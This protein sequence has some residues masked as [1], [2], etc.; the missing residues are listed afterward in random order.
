MIVLYLLA[1]LIVL[2][3]VVAAF[4]GTGWTFEKNVLI[5]APRAT[6]WDHVNSLGAINTWNPWLDRDPNLHQE[7]TGTDGTP[8]A[9]YSW[10]SKEKNVGAGRQTILSV[11]A[12]NELTTRIQFIRPFKGLAASYIRLEEERGYTR[13]AWG[14]DS[15]TPYPMNII[16]L[17][18]VIEKNMNRDF[19]KGLNKLKAICEK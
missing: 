17:F 1:G 5:R 10:D 2:F 4:V 13:A 19:T 14:I 6:V 9:T 15:S 3:L 11:A 16:K 8:G 18:G 12:P 7:L